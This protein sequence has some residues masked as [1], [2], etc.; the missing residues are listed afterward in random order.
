MLLADLGADVVRVDRPTDVP[1]NGER[2]PS[3]DLHARG[4]R[5]I[6]LD[7]KQRAD[8]DVARA[9]IDAADVLLDPY[10]PGVAERLG[11]GPDECLEA[12]PAP[13][14]RADDRV[15]SARSVLSGRRP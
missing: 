9:L 13:D 7:L 5:S 10:R 4:K 8:L 15:G 14:L 2:G 3:P 11:L 6:S 1:P 12:Q